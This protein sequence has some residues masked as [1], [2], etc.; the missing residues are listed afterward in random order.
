[1]KILIILLIFL[2]FMINDC[3]AAGGK[4]K[5]KV[6]SKVNIARTLNK[7]ESDFV[8]SYETDIYG[9]GTTANFAV[10]YNYDGWVVGV[11]MNNIQFI[12]PTNSSNNNFEIS[13]MFNLSKT[14]KIIDDLTTFQ[15]GTQVGT[16]LV[17]IK[18]RPLYNFNYFLFGRQITSWLNLQLGMYHANKDITYSVATTGYMAALEV[19][20]IPKKLIFQTTYISS[21][22][23]TSGATIN[24][25]YNVNKMIQPY[26]GVGLAEHN[27]NGEYGI[28]G[29]NLLL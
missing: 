14:F 18:P 9:I 23:N 29:I 8:L 15:I 10:N 25:L 20:I 28:V 16:V 19:D 12:G 4:A 2:Q 17:N 11:S 3:M 27:G 26:I 21:R 5:A 6:H 22:N 13:P 1:M 24:L 7:S